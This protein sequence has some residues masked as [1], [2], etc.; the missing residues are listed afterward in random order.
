MKKLIK[1]LLL[2]QIILVS[3]NAKNSKNNE[4]IPSFQD[5]LAVVADD[6][7]FYK[8][9][10]KIFKFV[11]T[12]SVNIKT[13]DLYFSYLDDF[14]VINKNN[15]I[16]IKIYK[17]EFHYFTKKYMN[18]FIVEEY[19][20]YAE[21]L[22]NFT[23]YYKYDNE[24]RLKKHDL[25]EYY[26]Q[27]DNN[28]F[29]LE[30]KRDVYYENKYSKTI[31][32]KNINSGYKIISEE[33][34]GFMIKY[35]FLF[36]SDRLI[37]VIEYNENGIPII[38]YNLKYDGQNF[39][40]VTISH[41]TENNIIIKETIIKK[42]GSKIQEIEKEGHQPDKT[43]KKNYIFRNHDAFDNWTLREEYINGRLEETIRRVIKYED[44]SAR[45]SDTTFP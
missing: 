39:N 17:D 18:G 36:D 32:I 31:R 20:V 44:V 8:L 21:H 22:E 9:T 30:Y 27:N 35:D 11:D 6:D 14:S 41:G 4:Q 38:F 15:I 24:G 29:S 25:L 16:E 1:L 45:V 37:K 26:Y 23:D 43:W 7:S 42:D 40:T 12:T 10:N 28:H 19:S 3:C 33:K 34:S 5:E 13:E 2:T